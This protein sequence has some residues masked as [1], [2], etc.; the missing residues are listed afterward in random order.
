RKSS[1]DYEVFSYSYNSNEVRFAG[2]IH[3]EGDLIVDGSYSNES[4]CTYWPTYP[5]AVFWRGD[6]TANKAIRAYTDFDAATGKSYYLIDK[7]EGTG[8]QNYHMAVIW[9][10]PRDYN[11]DNNAETEFTL[12]FELTGG[13]AHI[14]SVK[15]FR[16]DGLS[17]VLI[18]NAVVGTTAATLTGFTGLSE[19]EW[20]YIDIALSVDDGDETKLYQIQIEYER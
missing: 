11:Y 7:A 20:V 18:G 14:D 17:S 4:V 6:G 5:N 8:A 2:N 13:T 10:P 19:G 3:V 9:T 12:N 15:L 16:A 1:V